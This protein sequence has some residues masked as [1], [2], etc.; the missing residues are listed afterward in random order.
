MG[1]AILQ[2]QTEY[3]PARMFAR[4]KRTMALAWSQVALTLN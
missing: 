1:T 2:E 4:N 3:L